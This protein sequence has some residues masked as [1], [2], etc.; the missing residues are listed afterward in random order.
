MKPGRANRRVVGE[1]GQTESFWREEENLGSYLSVKLKSGQPM[2]SKGWPWIQMC[3]RGVLGEDKVAKANFLNDGKLLLKT[4]DTRQTERLLKAGKFGDE[5]CLI[6]REERLNQSRGTIH[7][8]DLMDVSE[9]E[10]VQGLEEFGVVAARRFTRRVGTRTEKTPVILLTFN[11]PT[12]PKRL[13]LDYVS[14]EVRCHI[15]NPLMC[16]NCGR[17][18]HMRA[19]CRSETACLTCGDKKHDGTCAQRCMH[20]NE[21]THSCLSKQCPL[22]IKEKTICEIKVTKEVSYAHA[23]H[24]YERESQ[25]PTL[26]PYASVVRGSASGAH[27][28]PPPQAQPIQD[29][30]LQIK[31]NDLEQK[32]D[33][34]ISLLERVLTTHTA[35][36]GE[37]RKQDAGQ[38]NSSTERTGATGK[39]ADIFQLQEDR[40]GSESEEESVN[41]TIT[42]SETS[43]DLIPPTDPTSP[44]PTPMEPESTKPHGGV[45]TR[46]HENSYRSAGATAAPESDQHKSGDKG[47]GN[48]ARGKAMSS[49]TRNPPS[50]NKGKRN[51]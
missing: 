18:G 40:E 17:Y 7:A 12:C 27:S 4:K 16:L 9:D 35:G 28:P 14:Y 51:K 30:S 36:E 43:Q 10:I 25:P 3:I 23:R 50:S 15:P 26:R 8:T 24:L 6:E 37:L 42:Q 38:E 2:K 39:V 45:K 44:D 21:N 32:L 41:T 47:Q 46:A 33:R 31:V 29:Q 11:R 19:Q 20:C 5:E 34:M 22:W 13:H 48:G 1:V 49:H